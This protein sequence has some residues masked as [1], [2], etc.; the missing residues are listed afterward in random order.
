MIFWMTGQSTICL[1]QGRGTA[2]H[3]VGNALLALLYKGFGGFLWGEG[4]PWRPRV[5]EGGG[6]A[7]SVRK[8]PIRRLTFS[9]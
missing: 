4:R 1:W 7:V 2:F 5:A 9:L 8:G 6:G 3:A